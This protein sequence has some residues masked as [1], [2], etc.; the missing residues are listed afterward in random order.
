M[1]R[2]RGVDT[3]EGRTLCEFHKD[4]VRGVDHR[5]PDTDLGDGDKICSQ[6]LEP[7]F[8]H[9]DCSLYVSLYSF[10]DLLDLHFDVK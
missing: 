8:Q 7:S 4:K 3:V 1:Q 9:E 10:K 6:M 5:I 2:D